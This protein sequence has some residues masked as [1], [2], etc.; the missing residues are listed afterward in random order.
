MRVIGGAVEWINYP[1][2][3]AFV[4]V[5]IRNPGFLGQNAVTRVISPDALDNDAL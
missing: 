3:I 2:P 4:I 5:R 1:T